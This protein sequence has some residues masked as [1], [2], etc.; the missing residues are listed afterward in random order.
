LKRPTG[1]VDNSTR[2]PARARSSAIW[3][4]DWPPPATSTAPD[5]RSPAD[6]YSAPL[7]DSTWLGRSRAAF[8]VFG[9]F[10][11]P[12]A[13]TTVSASTGPPG[14]ISRKPLPTCFKD[15]TGIPARIGR[16]T[17]SCSS[18]DTTSFRPKKAPGSISPSIV[19]IQSDVFSRKLSH[20]C[21]RQVL[22]TSSR[23]RTT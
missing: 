15:S 19:F 16:P 8:G 12:L 3:T 13:A 5:G 20:R 7:I 17:A 2:R 4:P 11:S 23:S 22:A 18:R 10:R 9:T 14:V 1:L 6:R 21:R